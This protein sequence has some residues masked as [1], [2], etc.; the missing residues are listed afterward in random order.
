MVTV[1]PFNVVSHNVVVYMN[2]SRRYT[3]IY[4]IVSTTL[5]EFLLC[6]TIAKAGS[7]ARSR[8]VRQIWGSH[9]GDFEDYPYCLLE[10]G[11]E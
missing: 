2:V 9:D 4:S 6:V 7:D 1:D 5:M 10:C 8:A 3:G 11:A